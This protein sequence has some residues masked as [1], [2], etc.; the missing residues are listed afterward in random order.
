MATRLQETYLKTIIPAMKEKYAYANP[1]QVPTLQKVVLNVGA[2]TRSNYNID[3][4]IENLRKI[5]GQ[6]PVKT[7][8]K[9]SISN[10]K[11]R[12]GQV[13]GLKVTLRGKRMYEFIDRFVNV[14]L[15]RVHDFRGLPSGG[16]D[17]QGNYSVGMKDQLAFPEIKA[18]ATEQLHGLQ[19]TFC[20]TAKDSE[21]A[22]DLLKLFGFP[23]QEAKRKKK[24]GKK[25]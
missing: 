17:Q 21:Q 18:E 15:P 8:A 25:S 11:S 5:T 9:Q 14:A 20:S 12:K 7:L 22:Y 13:I 10:F 4:V 6:Q 1:M 3:A 2:G 24:R 23:L 19:I 16:F